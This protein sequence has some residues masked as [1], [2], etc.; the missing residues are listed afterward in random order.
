M[1]TGDLISISVINQ[2]GSRRFDA[3]ATIR[4]S[5]KSV[6]ADITPEQSANR[7]TNTVKHQITSDRI[8]PSVGNAPF[9]YLGDIRGAV[10][11]PDFL[12][13]KD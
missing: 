5:G 3:V 8:Q 4:L 6:F 11:V 2:D 12:W 7:L 9:L 10:M 1:K 13:N